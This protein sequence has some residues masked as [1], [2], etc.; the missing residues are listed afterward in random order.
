MLSIYAKLLQVYEKQGQT[1]ARLGAVAAR[2]K[3]R[4][5]DKLR[6]HIDAFSPTLSRYLK[7]FK[8]LLGAA[9]RARAKKKVSFT[10]GISVRSLC[11]RELGVTPL[12]IRNESHGNRIGGTFGMIEAVEAQVVR[13]A[14]HAPERTRSAQHHS[15]LPSSGMLSTLPPALQ[16][17]ASAS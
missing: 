3:H 10:E 11:A 13:A 7:A 5:I 4:D 2:I 17:T 9:E 6:T 8:E 1:T 16:W 14:S 12:R 15:T